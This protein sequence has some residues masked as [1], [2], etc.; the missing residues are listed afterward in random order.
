MLLTG[1]I[2]PVLQDGEEITEQH[3]RFTLVSEGKIR[4][5]VLKEATLSDEGEYTC[6]LGEHECTAELTVRE[7]PA[8]IVR[9]M[10]DQVV[11]KGNRATMEVGS[12]CF[13]ILYLFYYSLFVTQCLEF[14]PFAVVV[15]F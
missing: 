15:G 4:K 1:L 5:L 12:R 2:F 13:F 10:K 14:V 8:E 9:K 11:S 3:K 6:A 7:L